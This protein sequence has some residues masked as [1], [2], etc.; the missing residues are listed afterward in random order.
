M[1]AGIQQALFNK[2]VD[3][4][5]V[6]GLQATGMSRSNA[7]LVNGGLS[8]AL[9]GSSAILASKATALP[10]MRLAPVGAKEGIA[11]PSQKANI[12]TQGFFKKNII[13]NPCASR[14]KD[15]EGM[16]NSYLGEGT[17][18]IKN[19]AGDLVFISKDGLRKV[20]FDFISPKPHN[21]PHMHVEHFSGRKWRDS[22]QIYPID[23]PHN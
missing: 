20:R 23:V 21:N 15:A 9:G 18:L 22:G 5:T 13:A 17:R 10:S 19:E 2:A 7:L 11:L 12:L 4:L 3:P 14:V 8:L 1:Q 16:I 6:Q